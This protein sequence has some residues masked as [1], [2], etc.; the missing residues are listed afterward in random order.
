MGLYTEKMSEKGVVV[1]TSE[2]ITGHLMEWRVLMNCSYTQFVDCLMVIWLRMSTIK[3]QHEKQI[4]INFHYPGTL[5]ERKCFVR[6]KKVFT[7]SSRPDSLSPLKAKRSSSQC[8]TSCHKLSFASATIKSNPPLAKSNSQLHLLLNSTDILHSRNEE[9]WC[10]LKAKHL[11]RFKPPRP[12]SS[13]QFRPI[14][15]HLGDNRSPYTPWLYV[16]ITASFYLYTLVYCAW[17]EDNTQVFY[18][19]RGAQLH[20]GSVHAGNCL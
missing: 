15:T 6:S 7:F 11:T 16:D 8:L 4:E 5:P 18:L 12:T 9:G 1:L 2:N 19:S 20:S 14:N 13:R 10:T 17:C 3:P